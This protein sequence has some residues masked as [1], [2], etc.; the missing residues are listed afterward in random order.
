M[1]K[2]A[3]VGMALQ[4]ISEKFRRRMRTLCW[5]ALDEGVVL[6]FRLKFLGEALRR[7]LR[8]LPVQH[9][10]HLLANR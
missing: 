10:L 3:P 6:F 7:E 9:R 5:E 8:V 4:T 2:T 1:N